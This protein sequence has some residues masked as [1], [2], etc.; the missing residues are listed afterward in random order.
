M[1]FVFVCLFVF[2]PVLVPET[3]FDHRAFPP[4]RERAETGLWERSCL[5]DL[6]TKTK[7]NN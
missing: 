4:D 6:Q 7:D 3:S 1:F 5:V 2:W